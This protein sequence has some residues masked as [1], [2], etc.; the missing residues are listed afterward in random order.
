[1]LKKRN[2]QDYKAES[3]FNCYASLARYLKSESVIQPCKLWDDYKFPK[4]IQTLDGKMKSLQ[5][6]GL[7]EI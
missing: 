4:A 2:G 5:I 6:K 1:M 3:V 7:G